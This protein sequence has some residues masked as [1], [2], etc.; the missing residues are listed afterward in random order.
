MEQECTSAGRGGFDLISSLKSLPLDPEHPNSVWVHAELAA[1]S[2][3]AK[4]PASCTM[5][6]TTVLAEL[7]R[8]S[9]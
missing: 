3:R 9:N 5:A 7:V 2:F 8:Q 4:A 6:V 1:F